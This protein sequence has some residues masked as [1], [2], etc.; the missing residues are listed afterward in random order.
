MAEAIL[1]GVAQTIIESL[2]S[3]AFQEIGSMWG[4]KGDLE[5]LKN[6]VSIIQA[7]LQDA[8]EQQGKHWL[9]KLNDAVYDADDLLADF[10]TA[11]LR[12]RVMG[13]D[14]MTMKVRSFFSSSNQLAFSLKMSRKIKAMRQRLNDIANDCNKFQLVERPLQMKAVIRE[15]DET[16]SFVCEEEIIGREEDR[17][18]LIDLLLDSDVEENVSFISIVGIGGLGKTTLAQYVYNDE[19]IMTSF[20]LRMWVCVSDVFDVKTIVENIIASVT[21]RTLKNLGMDRL[22]CELREQLNQKKYLLVLDDVWN[23][24]QERWFELKSLLMGGSKGSKVVITTR[25]K[26]VA[27]IAGT[28]SQHYLQGLSENQSW[29][30]FKQMAFRKGQKMINPNLEAIGKDIVRK[31]CGVPLAIK[32]IGRTLYFK[33]T[34]SDWLYIKDK[35]LKD[36]TQGAYGSGILPILKLSYDHLPSYLKCCFAYCSLFPKDYVISKLTLIQLWIAQGFI[37]SSDK[38]QQLED[39]AHEYFMNLLCRSFFQEAREDHIGNVVGFKMHDLIHDLAQSISMAECRIVDSNA[40]N[41]NENVHHLSIA[42][43]NVFGKNLS[44]LFKAKKIRTFFLKSDNWIYQDM[45]AL[46]RIICSFRCLRALDLHRLHIVVVPDSIANLTY[47]KYLDLSGN[48][49]EVL[50]S[51]IIRLLNLQTLK[52]SYCFKLKELPKNIQKLVNLRSLEIDGCESLTRMPPGLGQLTSLQILPLFLV[53]TLSYHHCG[54]LAEL[55]NLNNLR[56]ELLITILGRGKCAATEAKAANL[57]NKQHLRK[58]Q[59]RWQRLCIDVPDVHYDESLLEGLQPHQ[60]LKMLHVECYQGVRFPSWFPLLTVLVELKILKSSCHHLPPMCQLP[61]LRYLSLKTMPSLEYISEWEI[62]DEIPASTAFFPSLESLELLGCP[63]LKGW[64]RRDIVNV[65]TMA[66]TT[67]SQYQQHVSLPSFPCLSRLEIW[68]CNNLTSMP[69][70]P[71]L[72]E[73]L[74][75]NNVSCKPLQQTME[76]KITSSLPSSSYSYRPLSKL[77]SLSLFAIQDL[78][79]LPEQWFQNLAS[80]E[81]LEI[82]KCPRLKSLSLSLSVQ[83]LTSLKLLEIS[84]CKEV[85]L[86]NDDGAQSVSVTTLQTL[87]V[88]DVLSLITLPVWIGD[89][90]SL[91]NLEIYRC[92]NLK[93]LSDGIVNLTSLI[94]LGVHRCPN[95][96]SL[97]KGMHCLS[98]LRTLIII[99][100]PHLKERYQ[101]GLGEDWIAHVRNI[102]IRD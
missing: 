10:Y 37:H 17:K 22:Q 90:T 24:D 13:G 9:K 45:S 67:S 87:R 97:P 69:M 58:L 32:T 11:D 15:M 74:D 78:E 25:S 49:I 26:L 2:G 86:F 5:Q 53:N 23:E 79:F 19:K 54:G 7:V 93:S 99:G 88:S 71:Y 73:S 60:A 28:S 50:P 14:K 91:Q 55:N 27:E 63:N 66:S 12:R 76:M 65:G 38:T 31:C 16:C 47:L 82:L 52:L 51:S 61:H 92:P 34:E 89:L 95:L 83:Y 77:K 4:V 64:W 72:K 102:I 21:V 84:G 40:E 57:K 1:L 30:L 75:L 70:F 18:A 3:M 8:E 94:K 100:C 56:G 96:K 98:S 43:H 62:T 42:S 48:D 81:R 39:V 36:L 46:D 29:S 44:S 85:D 101:E 20:E 59:L 80:L 41:V 6:T 33:E 68:D 35:E